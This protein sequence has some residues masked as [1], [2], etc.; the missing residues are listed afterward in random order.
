M[1]DHSGWHLSLGR[2]AGV[3]V[4]LHASFLFLA[5]ALIFLAALDQPQSTQA[6]WAA[7]GTT[8]I[9]FASVLLHEM[10]HCLAAW[11]LGGSVTQIMLFPLGGLVPAHVDGEPQDEMRVAMAG[12]TTNLLV[13]LGLLPLLIW[14]GQ[15]NWLGLFNILSPPPFVEGQL[16]TFVLQTVFYVNWLLTIVN[17][18]P[19]TPLDGGRILRAALAP[20]MGSAQAT[21]VQ[22]RVGQFVA[23][24]LP[25]IAW[26][27]GV[28]Q[29]R[30]EVDRSNH[31]WGPVAIVGIML[32]FAGKQEL[33][34]V[35]EGEQ[36][37]GG[38]FGYDFSQG[39]TSLERR[40]APPPPRRKN[41][42]SRWLEARRRERE[43]RRLEIEMLEESRLDGIL[44]KL[45]EV[46]LSGLTAEERDILH[47][48]SER[49]R[50][51]Q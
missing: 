45:N 30:Q 11:R 14:N 46:G 24:L 31:F 12:P 9:L 2:W 49:Y 7:A 25:L 29:S 20:S 44:V 4:K 1:Q 50:N 32:Y 34:K 26:G 5:V 21:L 40:L 42:V 10:G 38:P 13:C 43:Q 27:I 18:I 48:V 6:G 16:T 33:D 3:R 37:E 41:A 23:L 28:V 17:L 39:Y 15:D 22:A 8:L 19:A 47:R 51:R 35:V 36:E